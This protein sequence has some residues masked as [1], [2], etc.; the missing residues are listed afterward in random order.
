[1]G[2]TKSCVRTVGRC[3]HL[4]DHVYNSDLVMMHQKTRVSD[5]L[6]EISD[7]KEVKLRAFE[8]HSSQTGPFLKQLATPEVSGEAQSFLE[9][10]PYWTYNFES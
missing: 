6:N 4:K 1:M 9:V 7:Y 8:A 3:Q 2:R 5:I 10:E